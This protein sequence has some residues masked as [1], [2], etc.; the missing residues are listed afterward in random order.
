MLSGLCLLI[1]GRRRKLGIWL[2]G[3]SL[4]WFYIWSAAIFTRI[5][6]GSLEEAFL[7]DGKW[8]GVESF[9]ACDAIA[10]MGGGVGVVTNLSVHPYLNSSADRAY[11]SALLWK[12]GKAS[13]VVPSGRGL[14]DSD[15]KFLMDLGV[16]DSAIIVDNDARNTEENAQFVDRLMQGCMPDRKARV[17]VVTSAWHMKRTLLMFEKYAPHIEAIPAACDFECTPVETFRWAELLPNAEIFG[18]NSVYLHE[19][20]GILWY[21]FFRK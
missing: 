5:V 19:W 6:G 13:V 11:F 10:D 20:L 12:A 8:P 4:V 17:L 21:K 3:L 2:T 1:V 16:P 9:P 7:V 14:V 15:R 18:R